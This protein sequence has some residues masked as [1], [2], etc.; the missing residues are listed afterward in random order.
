MQFACELN[1][2]MAFVVQGDGG[3]FI[4]EAECGDLVLGTNGEWGSRDDVPPKRFAMATDARDFAVI[5]SDVKKLKAFFV[6]HYP[7]TSGQ[8]IFFP[9]L[10]DE[11]MEEI[12][13]LR[14]IAQGTITPIESDETSKTMFE[15]FRQLGKEKAQKVNDIAMKTLQG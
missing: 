12:R 9:K 8:P 5:L 1:G 10:S 7:I 3:A 15:H 4:I 6:E 11:K 2:M 13:R 14:A